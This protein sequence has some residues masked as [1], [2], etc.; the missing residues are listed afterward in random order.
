LEPERE[1]QVAFKVHN[2]F[3]E[4]VK[5]QAGLPPEAQAMETL[6]REPAG[7]TLRIVY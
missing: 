2:L 4:P 7:A 6:V 1:A 3:I 5:N